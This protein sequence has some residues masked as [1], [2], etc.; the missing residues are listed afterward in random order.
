MKKDNRI[1]SNQYC[2]DRYTKILTP[3]FFTK[4]SSCNGN[5]IALEAI[6]LSGYTLLLIGGYFDLSVDG[7]VCPYRSCSRIDDDYGVYWAYSG[8]LQQ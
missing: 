3:Y 2:I 1:I 4:Q 7:I 8:L 6:A 5:N